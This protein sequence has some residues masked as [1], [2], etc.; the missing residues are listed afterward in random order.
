LAWVLSKYTNLEAFDFE[1]YDLLQLS[2]NSIRFV[3]LIILNIVQDME[4]S[5]KAKTVGQ[6]KSN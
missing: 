4:F 2:S 6:L 5:T 3:Y 1:S